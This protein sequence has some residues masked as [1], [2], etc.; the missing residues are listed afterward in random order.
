MTIGIFQANGGTAAVSAIGTD[1][2]PGVVAQSDTGQ[3]VLAAGLSG[4]GLWAIGPGG[5]STAPSVTAAILAS[6]GADSCIVATSDSGAAVSAI[7]DNGV[8][9]EASGGGGAPGVTATADS[10]SGVEAKSLTGPGVLGESVTSAGVSGITESGFGVTANGGSAGVA[11]QVI[12]KVEVQGTSV[13]SVTMSAGKKTLTV[14]NA[15][16]TAESLILLTPLEN[17]QAFLWIGA[18]S[19]GSFEIEAS[20]ALPTKVTIT[21]LIIN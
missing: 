11:L 16:A 8:G 3:A 9:V 1:G 18:R 21:F 17:P 4:I 7:S 6:S 12:G 10:G 15:S 5:V 20:K 14:S 13:G 19:A 2:S